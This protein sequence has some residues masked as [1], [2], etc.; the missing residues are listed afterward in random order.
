MAHK[1]TVFSSEND[2]FP[3]ARVSLVAM[4]GPATLK[5]KEYF[6]NCELIMSHGEDGN[7]LTKSELADLIDVL[8]H[9]LAE[10]SAMEAA[11]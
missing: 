4:S 11:Q 3:Q 1:E 6:H 7:S 2:E 5:P 8:Q 9:A 10:I